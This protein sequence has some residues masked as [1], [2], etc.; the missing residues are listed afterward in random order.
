MGKPPSTGTEHNGEK[1]K[2]IE[3]QT[4]PHSL[5]RLDFHKLQSLLN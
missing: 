3:S 4:A 1:K 2:T 5:T